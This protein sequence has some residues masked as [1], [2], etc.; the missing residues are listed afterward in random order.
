[1]PTL[2]RSACDQLNRIRDVFGL[3]EHELAALFRVQ[4]Q[5]V[6]EWRENGVPPARTA[7]VERLVDLANIFAREVIESRIPE[8]VRTE[9]DW[10]PRKTVLETIKSDGPEAIYGYLHRLFAYNGQ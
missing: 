8:I 6:T 1:M 9:D 4:R 5:S 3:S 2:N 7:S 10:L